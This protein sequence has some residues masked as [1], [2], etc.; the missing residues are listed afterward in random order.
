MSPSGENGHFEEWMVRRIAPSARSWLEESAEGESPQGGGSTGNTNTSAAP[1]L[2]VS[3]DRSGVGHPPG[4]GQAL[5]LP[6]GGG[7]DEPARQVERT[8]LT[9]PAYGLRWSR[10]AK[11][12]QRVRRCRSLCRLPHVGNVRSP[13][14]PPRSAS[15]CQPM[16]RNTA[17]A[18][19]R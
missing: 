19:R 7:R 14:V 4:H 5:C 10:L 6:G 16:R 2:V 3:A 13:I 18:G 8:E 9:R 11:P 17:M 12:A 15:A 1:W